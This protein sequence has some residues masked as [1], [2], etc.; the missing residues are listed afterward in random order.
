MVL[1]GSTLFQGALCMRGEQREE[2]EPLALEQQLRG[3]RYA[4]GS[5]LSFQRYSLS[6]PIWSLRFLPP[7]PVH[8]AAQL[9]LCNP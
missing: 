4:F 5:P 1:I 6:N 7:P 3:P 9:W 2:G 8:S